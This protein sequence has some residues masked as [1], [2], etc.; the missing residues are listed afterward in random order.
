MEKDAVRFRLLPVGLVDVVLRTGAGT[1]G[2]GVLGGGF[3]GKESTTQTLDFLPKLKK[4]RVSDF[5][6]PRPESLAMTVVTRSAIQDIAG[7]NTLV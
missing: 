1:S 5:L 2:R 7:L 4:R 6:K 3:G